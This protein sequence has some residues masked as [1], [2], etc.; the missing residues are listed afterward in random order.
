[1]EFQ[2][3]ICQL[4]SAS[5]GQLGLIRALI[6]LVQKQQDYRAEER[7]LHAALDRRTLLPDESL[8]TPR[9]LFRPRS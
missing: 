2:D 6:D 7:S 3:A 9:V 4:S 8:R 1:M 5:K